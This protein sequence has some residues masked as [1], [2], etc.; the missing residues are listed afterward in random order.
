MIKIDILTLFPGM[1]EG[2]FGESIIMRA[3]ERNLAEITCHNFRDYADSPHYQVDDYLFGGGSGMVL[4]AEPIDR[5]LTEL[6]NGSGSEN[7]RLVLPTPQGTPLRQEYINVLA[8][9]KRIVVLC[10]HYKGIDERIRLKYRPDEISLGDYVVTGGE[11]PAMVLVDAVVRLLPGA[12]E[13]ED[14]V[15][16][17]SFQEPFLDCPHFTRPR[18]YQGMEVPPVLLSGDHARIRAWRRK[19]SLE[20]TMAVRPD[21]LE[22]EAL[23]RADRKLM[24]NEDI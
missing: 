22:P 15:W 16:S 24:E 4:K 21:L 13:N 12:V 6:L 3:R 20:K 14:S 18:V 17:D 5:L 9:E 19:R 10:G 2:P 11:L 7:C 8:R 1:F 23:C